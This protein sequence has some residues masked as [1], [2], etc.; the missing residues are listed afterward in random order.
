ANQVEVV[1]RHGRDRHTAYLH[2][3]QYGVRIERSGAAD[4]DADFEQLGDRDFG[5]EFP[6]Y[7]PTRLAIADRAQLLPQRALVDF[8]DDA[9]GRIIEGR[10]FLLELRDHFV[11]LG[12]RFYQPAI[13]LDREPPLG[14]PFEDFVLRIEGRLAAERLDLETEDLQTA[15]ARH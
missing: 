15:T 5:R 10:Q 2:G 8:G 12:Q 13:R 1:Q 6:R 4:V 9:V 14:Q 3:F 11:R 7:R